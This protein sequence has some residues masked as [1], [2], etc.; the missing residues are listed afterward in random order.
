MYLT[1][2]APAKHRYSVRACKAT[3]LASVVSLE[4]RDSFCH[5]IQDRELRKGGIVLV[6]PSILLPFFPSALALQRARGDRGDLRITQ[7]I[8]DTFLK[9]KTFCLR[10]RKDGT[11]LGCL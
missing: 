1:S 7:R 10:V 8:S 6:S 9:C 4:G 2:D 3:S 5:I 11:D